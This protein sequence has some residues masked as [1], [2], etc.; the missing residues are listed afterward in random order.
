MKWGKFISKEGN[1]TNRKTTCSL[2]QVIQRTRTKTHSCIIGSVWLTCPNSIHSPVSSFQYQSHCVVRMKWGGFE[3]EEE[4]DRRWTGDPPY[5]IVMKSTDC[6]AGDA[7]LKA[8]SGSKSTIPSRGVDISWTRLELMW[9]K[10]VKNLFVALEYF[11][12]CVYVSASSFTHLW[13]VRNLKIPKF[14]DGW[15]TQLVS[16]PGSQ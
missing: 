4:V 7:E 6:T 15:S 8:S 10:M 13:R 12:K 9:I 2:N 14:G 1:V 11:Y 5:V 16:C 3:T